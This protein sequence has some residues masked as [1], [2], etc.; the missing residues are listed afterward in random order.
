MENGVQTNLFE[1]P[2]RKLKLKKREEGTDSPYVV[3]DNYA[4]CLVKQP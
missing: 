2:E 3:A 4:V 1:V